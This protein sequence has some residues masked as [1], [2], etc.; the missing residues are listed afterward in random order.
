MIERGNQDWQLMSCPTLDFGNGAPRSIEFDDDYYSPADGP[1]ESQYVFIDGAN[2]IDRIKGLGAGETLTVVELGVGT[3]L[4]L[5]LLMK[6]W[7]K[8]RPSGAQC[9][10]I[11]IEK[12]PLSKQQLRS[13]HANWPELAAFTESLR[14]RWPMPVP[15]CHRRSQLFE[16]FTADFWWED[17]EKAL[18]DLGSY[19][20]AWADIW[21]LDGFT[22]KR[23]ANMW[24]HSI[25]NSISCLSTASAVV[26]TFTAA[27][28]V[29]RALE[30]E[31][32]HV[33]K[34]PGFGKK[35]ECITAAR[36]NKKEPTGLR[37]GNGATAWDL[38]RT[39]SIP[40]HCIVV[41]AGLAGCHIA[42]RLAECGCRV[43]LLEQGRIASGGSTQPQGVIYTRPSHKHGNLS[44]FS[45]AA[46]CF[47]TDHHRQKFL[48]QELQVGEDGE[49][50]GYIQLTNPETIERLRAAFASE[51]SPVKF[52]TSQEASE[53]A[54]IPLERG[55]LYFPDSGWLHPEGI[56]TALVDHSRIRLLEGVGK[57]RAEQYESGLWGALDAQGNVLAIGDNVIL[58]TAWQTRD[59]PRAKF[60]PLQ[61]IRG[62]TTE[63]DSTSALADMNCTVCHEGYTPPARQGKHCIGATYG[64]NE[65]SLEERAE[66]HKINIAQLSANVPSL[67]EAVGSQTLTGKA[68]IRCATSD[69]LPIVGSIPDQQAFNATYAALR[70]DRKTFI[71]GSQPNIKGLWVLTGLGSRGLTSAPLLSELLVSLMFKRPP[72]VPRYLLQAVSP[73]RFLRRNLVKGV[74]A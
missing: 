39:Q 13:V 52:L 53:V 73:A 32:F 71:P 61:P 22:P 16:N 27:G 3:G 36:D 1:A 18:E 59:D 63:V 17:A 12:H 42:R 67:A 5:T 43:T 15:G 29:R 45:L 23:N 24:T 11:G 40:E 57:I 47:S 31:G 37:D 56:C 14:S 50:S 65:T 35:R 68:A 54:G 41:G 6:A 49:L 70:H 44:D 69:Y 8:H 58:T 28:H 9:H 20:S 48:D 33:S 51:D 60:L 55:G 7:A 10:Y 46:Y 26:A 38:P 30:G 64:L 4:N 2:A 66:D 21:F 34:R 25:I 19:G 74:T 72:P 62:Q